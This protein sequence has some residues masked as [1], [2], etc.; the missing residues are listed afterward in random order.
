MRPLA[1]CVRARATVAAHAV[2]RHSERARRLAR[3]LAHCTGA[4]GAPVPNF[5]S[6]APHTR[7]RRLV[8]LPY[9]QGSLATVTALLG[10]TTAFVR[11]STTWATLYA[12]ASIFYGSC[13][14]ALT[15]ATSALMV[16][17]CGLEQASFRGCSAA[18]TGD[19]ACG[20]LETST[21]IDASLA[22][23]CPDCTAYSVEVCDQ[24][25][26]TGAAANGF[27]LDALAAAVM[28]LMGMVS[29]FYA[30]QLTV[31]EQT[32][33][34]TGSA[35]NARTVKAAS[36]RR[37]QPPAEPSR[38][39]REPVAGGVATTSLDEQAIEQQVATAVARVSA[40]MRAHN[41]HVLKEMT[42]AMRAANQEDL[43]RA[44]ADEHGKLASELKAQMAQ[45]VSAHTSVGTLRSLGGDGGGGPQYGE[46]PYLASPTAYASTHLYNM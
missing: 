37:P 46:D 8:W 3:S 17:L 29:S 25:Q 35:V 10:V 11:T 18:E 27:Y 34:L 43:K 39:A 31:R 13:V 44:L 24:F 38:P 4:P 23:E 6:S 42:G 45:M 28:V 19:G 7:P 21:C 20:C 16:E 2:E 32:E 41:E 1:A 12:M 14:G 9:T 36:T 30:L 22:S 5:T 40:E 26:G 33:R 15:L